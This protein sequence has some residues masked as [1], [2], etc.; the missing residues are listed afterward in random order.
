MNWTDAMI[1]NC[2]VSE[3]YKQLQQTFFSIFNGWLEGPS[4]PKKLKKFKIG[5]GRSL[6]L[7]K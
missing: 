5:E 2:F 7:V 4:P 3:S 6:K 1:Y